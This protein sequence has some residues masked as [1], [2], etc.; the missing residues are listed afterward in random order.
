[1]G[2]DIQ[3]AAFRTV[4]IAPQLQEKISQVLSAIAALQNITTVATDKHG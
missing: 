1:M 2:A 4:V 3:F